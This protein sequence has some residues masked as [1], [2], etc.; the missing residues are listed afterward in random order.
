MAVFQIVAPILKLE[1]RRDGVSQKTGNPWCSQKV[2]LDCSQTNQ[3]GQTY[4]HYLA[5][6]FFGEEKISMLNG[7]QPGTMVQVSFALDCVE[8]QSQSGTMYW[9]TN[10]NGTAI[11]PYVAQQPQ[12]QSV[13][14]AAPAPQPQQ[15]QQPVQQQYQQPQQFQQP[16]P[17]PQQYQQ[18]QQPAQPQQ[19]PDNS[20]PF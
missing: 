13:Q 18:P 1:Q 15:Y 6:D 12:P 16:Q 4:Y 19:M 17:Q 2:V 5:V 3:M 10:I 7:L 8:R 9:S 14:Q 20:L 11:K